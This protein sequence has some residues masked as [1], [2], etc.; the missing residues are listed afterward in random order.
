MMAFEYLVSVMVHDHAFQGWNA[1]YGA[2]RI[3]WGK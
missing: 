2:K 1:P 3:A